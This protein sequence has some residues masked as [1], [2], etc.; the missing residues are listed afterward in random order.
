MLAFDDLR[1]QADA[2][3]RRQAELIAE[4]R[5][6]MTTPTDF[7]KAKLVL[8]E[9]LANFEETA[10][11]DS[12]RS[13]AVR[14]AF[15]RERDSDPAAVDLCAAGFE[16]SQREAEPYTRRLYVATVN[17]LQAQAQAL[18]SFI[19]LQGAIARYGAPD[20]VPRTD[21]RMLALRDAVTRAEIADAEKQRAQSALAAF[22][23]T[24]RQALQELSKA[25]PR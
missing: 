15:A 6:Y 25:T 14:S 18:D 7:P 12:V 23:R 17:T 3:L 4:M 2:L 19:A 21:P 13:A 24:Q 20:L 22:R 16:Y 9:V 8:E 10:R 11:L 1:P 5:R